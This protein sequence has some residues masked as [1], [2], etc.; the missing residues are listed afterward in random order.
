MKNEKST[1]ESVIQGYYGGASHISG[2]PSNIKQKKLEAARG[3][4]SI[5]KSDMGRHVKFV[6]VP[7]AKF[8]KFLSK[9]TSSLS[10]IS[11][12]IHNGLWIIYKDIKSLS[13]V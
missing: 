7:P 6:L 9:I 2:L 4:A 8:L 10:K 3:A 1:R 11:V 13:M 12:I 5:S